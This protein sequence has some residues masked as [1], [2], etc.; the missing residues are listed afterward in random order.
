MTKV[1]INQH[2]VLLTDKADQQSIDGYVHEPNFYLLH[3]TNVDSLLKVIH[4]MEVNDDPSNYL[5]VGESEKAVKELFFSQ[6]RMIRAA[7]GIVF[8][9]E[10]K[11][12]MIFRNGKWDLPKGKVEKSESITDAA[13]REVMEETGI[14]DARIVRPLSF[15]NRTQDA[16]Y[17]AYFL[18]EKRVLKQTH[19]FEMVSSDHDSLIPQ[20]EEGITA[21]GWFDSAEIK[22]HLKN[23]HPSIA[24]ILREFS[25]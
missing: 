22:E 23:T 8:N 2:Q 14:T 4:E 6:Y 7:G 16:T 3:I 17:H 11:M 1:F 25:E 10:K 24:W 5:F 15:S 19:W 18:K 21:A 9:D 20:Q 12:L 13:I